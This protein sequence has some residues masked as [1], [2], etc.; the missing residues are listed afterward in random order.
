[1]IT[2]GD[3]W[4]CDRCFANVEKCD[5]CF[6]DVEKVRSLFGMCECALAKLTEGIAFWG[7]E[8]AIAVLGMWRECDR[9]NRLL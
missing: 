5:P 8:G 4:M 9:R 1:M 7:L 2:F 3:V 6:G